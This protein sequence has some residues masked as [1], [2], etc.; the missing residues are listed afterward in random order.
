MFGGVRPLLPARD[1]VQDGVRGEEQEP[2][3]RGDR[4]REVYLRVQ[5]AV[6]PLRRGGEERR[7]LQADEPAEGVDG[8]ARRKRSRVRQR[9]RA[10]EHT[11]EVIEDAERRRAGIRLV[12]PHEDRIGRDRREHDEEEGSDGERN[13]KQEIHQPARIG[14]LRA[15]RGA[16]FLRRG[17]VFEH[18]LARSFLRVRIAHLFAQRLPFRLIRALQPDSARDEEGDDA[19]AREQHLGIRRDR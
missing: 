6:R 19:H 13:E 11:A 15:E 9:E 2:D 18:D 1:V 12:Q 8:V 5:R 17:G 3:Q 16:L 7:T 10:A 4:H 14:E